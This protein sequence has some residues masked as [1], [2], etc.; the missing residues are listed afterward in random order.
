MSFIDS[1]DKCLGVPRLCQALFWVLGIQRWVRRQALCSHEVCHL[2]G[3]QAGNE[4]TNTWTHSLP[5]PI[6]AEEREESV[7]LQRDWGVGWE[8]VW[9]YWFRH[10]LQRGISVAHDNPWTG[11]MHS[12]CSL[13]GKKELCDFREQKEGGELATVSK[14][15]EMRLVTWQ[16]QIMRLCQGMIR[17]KNSQRPKKLKVKD[18][19]Q[20]KQWDVLS[21]HRW[22]P[23]GL[24]A[25]CSQCW[26]CQARRIGPFPV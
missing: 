5:V 2:M 1:W 15:G 20:G 21:L 24:S 16:D 23:L 3:S 14:W 6:G 26:R 25:T 12:P 11:R 8:C 4:K 19:L 7:R 10:S 17:R 13:Q 22:P 18:L 9:G